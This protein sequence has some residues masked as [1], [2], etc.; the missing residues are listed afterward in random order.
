METPKKLL[1]PSQKK[2]ALMFWETETPKS[3]RKR[4]FPSSKNEKK[5]LLKIYIFR[6]MEHFNPNLEKSF[7]IVLIFFKKINLSD[8]SCFF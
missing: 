2:A 3:L 6:E 4:N 1:I 5:P 7:Y 8:Y